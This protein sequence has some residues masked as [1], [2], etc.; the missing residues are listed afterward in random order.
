MNITTRDEIGWGPTAAASAHPTKGIVIHY[1]G[2]NQGLAGKPHAACLAYWRRTRTF[3]MTSPDRKWRDIGYSYACCPHG[4]VLEGRGLGREQA[5]QPGGNTT[6]YSVTLMSGPAEL[7]TDVQIE[8]VRELRAY[9]MSKG[10]GGGVK[11]HR[12]FISTTCPGGRLYGLI[13]DGT[14]SKAPNEEDDMPADEIY[15]AAW[16]QDRMPVPYGSATNGKWKPASVLVDHGVKLRQILAAVE[17]QGATIRELVAALA[18]R[19]Q[20]IDVDALVGRIETAIEGITVRLDV[21]DSA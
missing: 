9:L 8:A 16:E 21:P 18:Q 13:K 6:W 17:A 19:D 5:A 20:E 14:F 1:D 15:R 2:S 10:V 11:G 3:H 7:P 4:E 12:D